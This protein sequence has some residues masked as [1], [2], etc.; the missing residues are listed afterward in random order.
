MNKFLSNRQIFFVLYCVIIG[1]GVINISKAATEVAGTGGWISVVIATLIFIVIS[2]MITYLQY[3]YEGKTIYEYSMQL[4]GKIP[5]YILATLAIIYFF[6]FLTMIIR[7]YCETIH[8]TI[9]N[10]TPVMYLCLLFFMVVWYALSKGIN[11]I[12]R[13]CEIYGILN[14]VFSV[15]III[16]LFTQGKI[17]NITPFFI[18]QDLS[19][20]FKGVVKM[21][22]PFMGVEM[23]LLIPIDRKYNKKIFKYTTLLISF[24]GI[25]YIFIIES[26][27]SVV[28]VDLIVKLEATLFSVING[29]DPYFLEFFR[30]LDGIAIIFWTM[31]VVCGTS[32]WEYGTITLI[33]KIFKNGNYNIILLVV[34][35]TGFIIS[36]VP[37]TMNGISKIIKYNSYFGFVVFFMTVITFFII[38][39]VKKYDKTI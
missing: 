6:V 15:C 35:I 2:Y 23:L 25:L 7:I 12:G 21:I 38:T 26:T 19:L 36:Q 1:Y 20:Y 33:N 32:L 8:L 39:K 18:K 9:L 24:I 37:K 5:T 4:V 3:V 13:L 34:T 22:L 16:I 27:I 28:G 17:V 29:V 31:N 30:R 11:T 14:I 10:K